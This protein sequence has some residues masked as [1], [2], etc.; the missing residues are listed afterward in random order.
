MAIAARAAISVGTSAAFEA[1]CFEVATLGVPSAVKGASSPMRFP[2]M[3]ASAA[4]GAAVMP[5]QRR[6]SDKNKCRQEDKSE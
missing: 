1:G 4:L 2:A 3:R 5:S 6:L